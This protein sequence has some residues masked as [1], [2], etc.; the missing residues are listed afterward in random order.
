MLADKKGP[1]GCRVIHLY[2]NYY[3]YVNIC[4]FEALTD[5]QQMMYAFGDSRR[6]NLESAKMVEQVDI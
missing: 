5:T 2:F 4:I 3:I 6:P 1:Q